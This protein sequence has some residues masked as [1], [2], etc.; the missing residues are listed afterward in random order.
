[1]LLEMLSHYRNVGGARLRPHRRLH[2]GVMTSWKSLRGEMTRYDK[3]WPKPGE[4]A[5]IFVDDPDVLNVVHY[6]DYRYGEPDENR[7]SQERTGIRAAVARGGSCLHGIQLDMVWPHPEPLD[8]I[9]AERPDLR[10]ILQVGNRAMGEVDGDVVKFLRR[11]QS[12]RG[13]IDDVLI[14]CSGGQGIGMVADEYRPYVAAL[15]ASDLGLGVTVAGG[16]GPETLHL[17]EPLVREFPLLSI[18]A[19]GQLRVG[20][21][22][23][24]IDRRRAE[25]YLRGAVDL[26]ASVQAPA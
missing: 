15:Y 7:V 10:I 26:F 13:A 24:P 6:A 17:V 16:L 21:S 18:D 23:V 11:I 5:G 20:G 1:M 3:V 9:K 25:D 8:E 12:Y 2:A 22:T 14:D 19:Q 4:I